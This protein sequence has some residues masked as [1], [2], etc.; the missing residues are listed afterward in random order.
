MKIQMTTNF[1]CAQGTELIG[2]FK[3]L[4]DAQDYCEKYVKQYQ[5]ANL[6]KQLIE[7]IQNSNVKGLTNLMTRV[8]K[9][10]FEWVS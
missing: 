4:G 9:F 3:S 8:C 5:P 2:W 6:H 10:K 7:E 1:G